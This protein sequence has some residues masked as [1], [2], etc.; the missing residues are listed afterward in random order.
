[1]PEDG[2]AWRD[3]LSYLDADRPTVLD[4]RTDPSVPPIPLH[5]TFEQAKDA[6]TA[7]LKGDRRRLE[8]PQR[9]PDDQSPRNPPRQEH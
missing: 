8:R 9:R 2:Q 3:T 7:L 4:F 6:A 1:M 5:A